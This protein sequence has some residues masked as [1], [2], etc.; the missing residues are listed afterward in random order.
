MIRPHFCSAAVFLAA[1]W[2][3]ASPV[4]SNVKSRQMPGTH[5]VEIL[6]DLVSD[7]ECTLAIEV[8]K[9]GGVTYGVVVPPEAFT[10]AIGAGV[11]GGTGKRVVFDAAKSPLKQFFSKQIRF[12]VMARNIDLSEGLVAYYPFDGS[13]NDVSGNCNHGTLQGGVTFAPG[14]NGMAAQFD[15]VNDYVSVAN[16][17]GLDLTNT[18][19]LSAWIF[20][21]G[22]QARGYRIVDKCPAG[23]ADG[24]TFDTY[25]NNSGG[26][27]LRLQ[28]V[29][30]TDHNVVGSTDYTLLAWHHVVATVSETIGK[31]YMDG[32]LDG[33]GLV[34]KIPSN[35]LDIFIGSPHPYNGTG[36]VEFFNG[37]IDDVRIY[38][39]TLSAAEVEELYKSE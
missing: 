35:N 28:A 24:W 15:G 13:G 30:L 18:F 8:S 5:K 11:L 7:R 4:V 16:N 27:R 25:G 38:N 20:Q 39:R 17:S 29:D 31:V 32:C 19:T 14:R 36:F 2:V 1:A 22:A 37:L 26:R 10:G 21:K 3:Q 6:Y 12:K 33:E 34:G 23:I 9:D